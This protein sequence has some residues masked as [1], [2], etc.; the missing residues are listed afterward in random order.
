MDGG[1]EKRRRQWFDT[2]KTVS[3]DVGKMTDAE[4]D[5]LRNFMRQHGMSAE[6]F[7]YVVPYK[8][9]YETVYVGMG[10]GSRVDFPLKAMSYS[11]VDVY[12]NSS[13][14]NSN[15]WRVGSM[16]GTKSGQWNSVN[17]YGALSAGDE[18]RINV[19]SGH[20]KMYAH[21]AGGYGERLLPVQ[22]KDGSVAIRELPFPENEY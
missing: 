11:S 18:V 3:F 8:A 16:T 10:D 4:A 14:Y 22:L 7:T 9:T 12:V 2:L 1:G 20:L 17:F 13:Q 21:F 15:S 5:Y 19:N 6:G